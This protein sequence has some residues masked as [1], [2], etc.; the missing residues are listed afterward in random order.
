MPLQLIKNTSKFSSISKGD[1][2]VIKGFGSATGEENIDRH[3]EY[4]KDPF[5]FDLDNF[6]NSP[7]LWLDHDLIRTPE[8]NKVAAGK[9]LKAIPSF[10][11]GEDPTNSDNWI[12]S[13]LT[14]DKFVSIWPK[15]K[16]PDLSLNSQGLFI[17]AEVNH[18][19]A[20]ELVDKGELG[21]FSWSGV[22]QIDANA[23][24]A[25]DLLE[26]SLVHTQSQKSSTFMLV[27]ET[28]PTLNLDVDFTDC[29]ICSLAFMKA[30]KSLKDVKTYTKSFGIDGEITQTDDSYIVKIENNGL[31]TSK[32]FIYSEGDIVILAA[33][34]EKKIKMP[35][36]GDLKT[37]PLT[38]N[39]M[40]HNSTETQSQPVEL[41][42]TDIESIK[43]LAP[44]LNIEFEK[45]A[46]LVDGDNAT[47]VSI[48][49]AVLKEGAEL[50]AI[51]KPSCDGSCSCKDKE[52]AEAQTETGSE[53]KSE[54]DTSE[55]GSEESSTDEASQ[56]DT[57]TLSKEADSTDSNVEEQLMTIANA[58]GALSDQVALNSEKI[59]A[60][61]SELS[62]SI[63]SEVDNKL[64]AYQ[65]EE[66]ANSHREKMKLAM[67]KLANITPTDTKTQEVKKSA[68][69][70]T[71]PVFDG[72][73]GI[74]SLFSTK[75]IN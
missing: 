47:E 8:G 31:D 32:Q 61:M 10:I 52:S 46:S 14:T 55:D 57:E 41:I 64:S 16:C 48:H 43:A 21:T 56:E 3:G 72:P 63:L 38:E 66:T 42:L 44:Q 73:S 22:A 53:S 29:K 1:V 45:N 34:K 4:V 33:P 17:V 7:Q 23:I 15:S 36:V 30:N 9:V 60:Q 18:P 39:L 5:Q 62:K 71:T 74:D 13:S 27:D 35:I 6:K 19:F 50:D 51:D 11:S 75:G 2:R 68:P 49:S 37:K 25:I 69:T 24:K 54:D 26:F 70:R 12:I 40:D 28:D 67:K 20:I 58:V 59:N 65:K